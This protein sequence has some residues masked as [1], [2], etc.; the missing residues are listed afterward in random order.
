L[1][2]NRGEGITR[3]EL[4]D[5]ALA[6]RVREVKGGTIRSYRLFDGERF[7]LEWRDKESAPRFVEHLPQSLK[8]VYELGGQ[9]PA[10]LNITLDI[11]EMLTRLNDGYRPSNEEKQGLYLRL[12][13]FKNTLAAAPYQEVLLTETGHEFYRITRE[14]SGVLTMAKVE[15]RVA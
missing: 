5:H 4:L 6:L 11:Y 15:R 8:L 14:E 10:E 13:V 7:A 3:P 1:A 12:A 9:R 2:I